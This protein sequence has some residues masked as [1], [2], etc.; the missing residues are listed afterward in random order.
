[1]QV[2]DVYLTLYRAKRHR[3]GFPYRENKKI[4]L[5]SA[6]VLYHTE[7]QY[8][9]DIKTEMYLHSGDLTYTTVARSTSLEGKHI[10]VGVQTHSSCIP[11]GCFRQ[12]RPYLLT[13]YKERTGVQKAYFPCL[14]SSQCMKLAIHS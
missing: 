9:T 3:N 13:T 6:L 7:N 10:V 11:T 4:I 1:M 8:I 5:H 2:G 14:C 12:K